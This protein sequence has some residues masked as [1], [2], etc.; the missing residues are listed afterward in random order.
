M[1]KVTN[2]KKM[3]QGFEAV[4]DIS[5]ELN[6]GEVLAFLGPN[7]AGKTT[8]IKTILNLIIPT[9][10]EIE[11]F[12][13]K[14]DNRHHY[15]LENIGAVLE[16]SRNLYWRMSPKENFIYW[17]GIRGIS[18]KDAILNGLSYLDMFGIGDKKDIPVRELSRGMQQIVSIC[19]ALLHHPKIL[20]LDEPTLGLDVN[21]SD[22]IQEVISNLVQSENMSVL[23]TTHQ[24]SVAQNLASR[25]IM[26]RQGQIIFDQLAPSVIASFDQDIYSLSFSK[27]ITDN[28]I[29][30]ISQTGVVEK[31]GRMEYQV[32]LNAPQKLP[33]L[34]QVLAS[35]PITAVNKQTI[36]LEVL[37]RKLINQQGVA[38]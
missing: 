15:L 13:E 33:N 27:E 3:Y 14:L 6:P 28:L 16:G 21:A 30:L 19:C 10:G 17:G 37:F 38:E 34:L 11:V 4:H 31:V 20:F 9:S 8:T 2:L 5:F 32:A 29:D 25:I 22:K 36:D 35:S 12:G 24:M 23:L 1:L 18:N 26:I 7:G